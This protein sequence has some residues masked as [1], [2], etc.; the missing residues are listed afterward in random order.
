MLVSFFELL[1]LFQKNR[2]FSKNSLFCSVF[3]SQQ[4]ISSIRNIG[5]NANMSRKSEFQDFSISNWEQKWRT[6]QIAFHQSVVH[7]DLQRYETLF[8]TENCRVYIPLCGKSLDLIYL[9]DK[10]H[11]VYGCEFVEKAIKDFFKENNLKYTTT[12]LLSEKVLAYKA[13]SRNITIYQGDFFVLKSDVIG[14]FDAIW[15]RASLV[16][17]NP[18]QR[19]RYAQVIE[20]LMSPHTKYLLNAYT[21]K[22]AKDEQYEGPP[23][24]V[25]DDDVKK[26]FSNF[27]QSFK[28]LDSY[29]RKRLPPKSESLLVSNYIMTI[30]S[31]D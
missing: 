23:H 22:P 8:L 24:S 19:V 14:K 1:I 11:D 13:L 2:V 9:A 10:G 25:P 16:A 17:I 20:D 15:D 5:L 12:E 18:S 7:P 26:L 3:S 6:D 28:F 27:C 4:Q 21:I 29:Y 30:Q 31:K